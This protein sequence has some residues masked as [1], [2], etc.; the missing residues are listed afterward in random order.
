MKPGQYYLNAKL[1]QRLAVLAAMMREDGTD[2]A[3][4]GAAV[5]DMLLYAI[6]A[7]ILLRMGGETVYIPTSD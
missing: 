6:D 2:V 1:C 7:Q 5:Q 3:L 4:H